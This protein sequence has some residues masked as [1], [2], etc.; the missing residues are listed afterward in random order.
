MRAGRPRA[1][2]ESV[3]TATRQGPLSWFGEHSQAR[4]KSGQLSG[5]EQGEALRGDSPGFSSV[6]TWS[7]TF[8]PSGPVEQLQG[9]GSE[10]QSSA[11]GGTCKGGRGG[12]CTRLGGGRWHG[13]KCHAQLWR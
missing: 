3:S 9:A 12:R 7:T 11:R 8:W 2:G 6:P 13:G 5:A 1:Q 10:A 4:P